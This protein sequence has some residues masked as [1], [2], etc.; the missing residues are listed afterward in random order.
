MTFNPIA[1][2]NNCDGSLVC[3]DTNFGDDELN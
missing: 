1:Q 3:G 2:N